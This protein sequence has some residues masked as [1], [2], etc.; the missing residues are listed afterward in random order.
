L[1]LLTAFSQPVEVS[2]FYLTELKRAVLSLFEGYVVNVTGTLDHSECMS[3]S[4]I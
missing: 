4:S 1:A 2:L 3:F